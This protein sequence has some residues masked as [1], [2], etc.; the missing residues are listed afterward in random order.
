MWAQDHAA[1]FS[2]SAGYDVASLPVAQP[3]EE[4]DEY[5]PADKACKTGCS[6]WT[7]DQRS[8]CA[9]TTTQLQIAIRTYF[10]S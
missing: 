6:Q 9:T 2:K 1:E 3:V 4:E 10:I 7:S 5:K 8:S